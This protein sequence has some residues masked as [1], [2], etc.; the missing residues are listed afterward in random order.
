VI[1]LRKGQRVRLTNMRKARLVIA[2]E[3]IFDYDHARSNIGVVEC[4]VRERYTKIVIK[5]DAPNVGSIKVGQ[6]YAAPAGQAK[7]VSAQ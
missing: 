2:G 3:V 5:L 6:R 4:I 7:R 1:Q